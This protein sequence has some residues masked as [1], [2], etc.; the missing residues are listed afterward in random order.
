MSTPTERRPIYYA[1]GNHMHWA[2]IEWLWG[3]H[4]LP[5]SI[6]DMLRVCAETG[7]HGHIN[8]D[9]IAY[10][11]LAGEAPR[12]LDRLRTAIA[13][14]TIEVVGGSYGQPYGLF[15]GGESNVRQL[16]YGVRT[17]ERLLDIRPRLFWEEEFYFFPQLP[18]LLVAAGY[19]A[20]AL[21]FK[22]TWHTP[23]VPK[24]ETPVIQ[25]QG[26]DGSRLPALSRN[27]LNVRQWPEEF[28]RLRARLEGHPWLERLPVPLVLQWLEL[29][30]SRDW[31]CR[32]DVILPEIRALIDDPRYEV[33]FTPL[34]PYM[35]EATQ[36]APVRRYTLDDVFHG[37]S[38]GKNGDLFRR[39][40]RQVEGTLLSA[41]SLSAVLGIFG[42]PYASWDLYPVWEMEEAS[43]R[44]ALRT[45]P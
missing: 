41:E 22:E 28:R 45:T 23:F 16:L 33:R 10:E 39:L 9:G 15:H 36:D 40:S 19:T 8:F 4:V 21:F 18:Q 37:M 14:G 29:M 20:A 30:P 32:S 43:A 42:R 27:T 12:A 38:I 35:R 5:D 6:D 13:A 7:A 44:A 2:D 1:F 24:E 31:M 34:S 26:M 3:Y 11:K 17:V 25:W